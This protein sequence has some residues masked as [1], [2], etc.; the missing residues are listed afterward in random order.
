MTHARMAHVRQGTATRQEGR[1][2]RVQGNTNTGGR[3][4]ERGRGQKR[5]TQPTAR[6]GAVS[7]SSVGGIRGDVWT[8]GAARCP[9]ARAE[10]A[11]RRGS[12]KGAAR[13]TLLGPVVVELRAALAAAAPVVEQQLRLAPDLR[14]RAG[15]GAGA[16]AGS[17][18]GAGA[19]AALG[20][21]AG[22]SIHQEC[23]AT[24]DLGSK[25]CAATRVRGRAASNTARGQ[26]AAAVF[27][28][29]PLA[30]RRPPP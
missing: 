19:M 11:A 9:Q 24:C 12:E 6:G 18:G 4:E 10:S 5:P 2:K 30:G 26:G 1:I 17:G 13:L 22:K 20:R 28:A 14:L 3:R 25:N 21:R 7:Q 8:R 23:G 15:A 27:F 29:L 16:W